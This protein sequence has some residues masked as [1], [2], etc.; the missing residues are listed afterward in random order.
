MISIYPSNEQNFADNGLKILKP[1]RC[2]VYKED[3]G[4]YNISIRDVI[5]NLEYYQEG[6]ILRVPTPWGKQCFRLTNPSIENKKIECI[7]Y[8]LYFDTENYIIKDSY[9]V[10]KNCNDALDHLNSACDTETPFSTISDITVINS[11]RCVR[12]QL[13]EAI[14]EVIERWGGHLVRDNFNIGIR[15]KIGE[16][17]G[18]VIAY[19][20][21]IQKIYSKEEWNN[22]VTKI[23]P[24]GK[25][26]LLLDEIYLE[27]SD[28]LY[29]IPYSKV[30]QIDQSDIV[31]DNYKDENG[32]LD[33]TLYN[34]A[35][36]NDLRNK[37]NKYLQDNKLP[38]VNYSLT[39]YIK[40]ISDIGDIIYVSHPKCKINLTTNV[41]GIEY[42]VLA[43]KYTKIEFGNFK[44][45]LKD[46]ISNVTNSVTEKVNKVIDNSNSKLSKDLITA[47]NKIW[48][49]MGKSFV[50]NDGD[51]I[52][53]VDKLPKEEAKNVIMINN[54]GIG[55]SQTGIN[56][57]FNSAWTID[58][59]LDMQK[60]NVIN[61]VADMIKGGTLKLGGLDNQSGILEIY[62]ENNIIV[63][64]ID[65][66]GLSLDLL[67]EQNTKISNLTS[68][69][70]GINLQI[71]KTGG[72]NLFDNPVAYFFDGYQTADDWTG[73]AKSYTNTEI[74]NNTVSGNSF[75]LQN[76]TIEQI[77][78]K[79]N[80]TY[81]VSFI[82]KK[83]I[84]LAECSIV[85]NGIIIELTEENWTTESLTFEVT[86]NTID[87][88]MIS[89]T[90]DSCYVSDL[91]GSLGTLVKVWS[92]NP[93]E[94]VNGGVKIGKGIEIT[95]G[96]SNIKQ[97]INNDGNR[98][99]NTNT[100]EV[101]SEFTDK[102]L[103]TKEIIVDKAQV[104][105]LL[106]VDMGSQTW[107]S[108]M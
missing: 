57:I 36:I 99:V 106:I 53:I 69:V 5:E 39:A 25:D 68:S 58:G 4:D 81:T 90:N 102:G 66:N 73:I 105:K 98:I 35:L 54:G 92:N 12:K 15:Q 94:A 19:S 24:V 28:D 47:T 52:L 43:D 103:D 10:D 79:P 95:S 82:Y 21:N 72:D 40:D 86:A 29:D 8:H 89:N 27:T 74:K 30:I 3:N 37:G 41:I 23:M 44:N 84:A 100:N 70:N 49:V 50:I 33:E 80:G 88:Q 67:D 32:I 101:V 56:G 46:L 87:I 62:D 14:S 26:G 91:I 20:K 22:V 18:V 42:D 75:L 1:L 55:F 78:Q 77:V 16:D 61:L 11:Y 6:M 17:R 76:D 83:L 9:V 108:R 2:V 51:K 107:I 31:E 85:I 71:S 13:N 7:G 104:A 63:G 34:N 48:D 65:K 59:V 96:I 97:M 38:K 60:I 45:K 64:K 93:N